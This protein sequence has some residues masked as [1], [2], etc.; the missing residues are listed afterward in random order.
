MVQDGQGNDNSSQKVF[1]LNEIV[2][3]VLDNPLQTVNDPAEEIWNRVKGLS[4]I[5]CYLSERG[6][7]VADGECTVT[8]SNFANTYMASLDAETGTSFK[9]GGSKHS[10][11]DAITGVVR[12]VL[13]SDVKINFKGVDPRLYPDLFPEYAPKPKGQ[14]R[15]VSGPS[16]LESSVS[17]DP[18]RTK[19]LLEDSHLPSFK[20][21]A[22]LYLHSGVKSAYSELQAIVEDINEK[23]GGRAVCFVGKNGVG[24]TRLLCEM[25]KILAKEGISTAYLDL[26]QLSS[27]YQSSAARNQNQPVSVDLSY[28]KGKKVILLDSI[29]TIFG[30]RG[31]KDACS[32]KARI[33]LD[34][35]DRVSTVICSFTDKAYSLDSFIEDLRE[36]GKGKPESQGPDLA[37]R[38]ERCASINISLPIDDRRAFLEHLVTQTYSREGIKVENPAQ[39]AEIIDENLAQGVTV[40]KM[41]GVVDNVLRAA[42][43]HGKEG[44]DLEFL[45]QVASYTV[46]T[47]P[48]LQGNLFMRFFAPAQ[49]VEAIEG[50]YLPAGMS[51]TE[52]YGPSQDE[53]TVA[54]RSFLIYAL[55]RHG[56]LPFHK[57]GELLGNRTGAYVKNLY[58]KFVSRLA[59]E[60]ELH[61][62]IPGLYEA[63]DNIFPPTPPSG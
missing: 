49:I 7:R 39:F 47:N 55:Y 11:L 25:G 12:A 48:P 42:K 35:V 4:R 62:I 63:I 6:I 44:I 26:N 50:Y 45:A 23:K 29:E 10:Y 34:M 21:S 27:D 13:G 14:E 16:R 53:N 41:E 24:K 52:L 57:I 5:D 22:S 15:H 51:V 30:V 17:V 58:S 31:L 38:L 3:D 61:E 56:G 2:K 32:K 1:S 19:K 60:P 33:V 36:A 37:S 40:R 9:K 20:G 54:L 8:L 59:T 28:I 18:S 43:R 46:P